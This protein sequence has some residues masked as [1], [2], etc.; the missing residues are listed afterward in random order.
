MGEILLALRD[1][2]GLLQAPRFGIPLPFLYLA[3]MCGVILWGGSLRA[4]IF[5][6]GAREAVG[7]GVWV[8]EIWL[9][10]RLLRLMVRPLWQPV[11]HLL[12][13]GYYPCMGML[14]FL[15][16]WISYASNR[17]PE[18][19]AL[20][21]WLQGLLLVDLLLAGLALTNDWHQLVFQIQPST[22]P[23]QDIYT[24]GF[25]YYLILFS[26]LAQLLLANGWL[27]WR[28]FREKIS[29]ER[30]WQP[31][32]VILLYGGYIA[33]YILRIPWLFRSELVLWSTFFGFLWMEAL[34]R[35]RLLPGNSQ[36]RECFLHSRLGLTIL[37]CQGRTVY[38]CQQMPIHPAGDWQ[39]RTMP[40]FGGQVVWY[41]DMGELRQKKKKLELTALTLQRAYRL[42]RNWE[43]IRRERIHQQT[44]Q[45]IYEEVEGILQSKEPLFLQYARALEQ[46]QPGEGTRQIVARLN[47]LACYLKKECV[48]LLRGREDNSLPVRELQ[49]AVR[50][51]CHYLERTGLKTLVDDRLEGHLPVTTALAFFQLL[52]EASEEA[53]RQGESSQICCFK[54]SE[55]GWE[56]SLL[57]DPRPWVREFVAQHQSRYG[58]GLFCRELEYGSSLVLQHQKGDGS[59]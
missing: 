37:D 27:C 9:G 5:Q 21:R 8:W 57:W 18:D 42:R 34:L 11:S 55:K 53:V 30:L 31:L 14:I 6:L 22:N 43:K 50:E 7:W 10:I 48:L 3:A 52:E 47:V 19:R 46:A 32:T 33:G 44:K 29:L 35:S 2:L 36:Y 17:T 49:L 39:R 56:L 51:L 4:R 16:V 28:A 41:Q 59:W 20:P 23:H 25:V 13:Y 38:Q 15:A 54:E 45:R 58:R 40:I 1:F 26:Y 24:Y 12:W